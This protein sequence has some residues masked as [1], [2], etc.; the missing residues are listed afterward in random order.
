MNPA[1]IADN[2]KSGLPE[3]NR[4]IHINNDAGTCP[5]DA[6]RCTPSYGRYTTA[7]A[8][9]EGLLFGIYRHSFRW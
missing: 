6:L 9:I 1:S 2:K 7:V 8:A 5:I 3:D 4:P